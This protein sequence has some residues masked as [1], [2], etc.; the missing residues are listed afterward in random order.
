[1][2]LTQ[3]SPFA[4][5][6]YSFGYPFILAACCCPARSADAARDGASTDYIIYHF[7]G[8][9]GGRVITREPSLAFPVDLPPGRIVARRTI[10]A[11]WRVVRR[12]AE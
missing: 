6:G 10:E 2:K 8:A 11:S 5:G 1:M 12:M 9:L 7:D 4:G 3:L